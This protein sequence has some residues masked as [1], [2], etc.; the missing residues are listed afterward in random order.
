MKTTIIFFA[1]IAM[2]MTTK[3]QYMIKMVPPSTIT[4]QPEQYKVLQAGDSLQL[5]ITASG[6]KNYQ[7]YKNA[8][9]LVGATSA[10]YKVAST[11]VNDGGAYQCI[12]SNG[13]CQSFSNTS[14]VVVKPTPK[15]SITSTEGQFGT[16]TL[17]ANCDD[18]YTCQWFKDGIIIPGAISQVY[19]CNTAQFGTYEVL[20]TNQYG[21]SSKTSYVIK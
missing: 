5:T 7:W 6:A 8:I 11:S 20:V 1:F 12:V 18:T 15:V 3:A 21:A 9:A 14:Y 19:M 17:R 16:L 2:A 10:T 4:A 13:A